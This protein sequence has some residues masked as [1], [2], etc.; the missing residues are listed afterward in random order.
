MRNRTVRVSATGRWTF[1]IGPEFEVLDNGDSVQAVHDARMAYVSS[2]R[3]GGPEVLIPSAQLR[4]TAARSLGSGERFSH[5][6]DS[7]EGDAEL[8]LDSKIWRLRGTMCASGTVATCMIDLPSLDA[9]DW[10]ISV[11]RSLRCE[12]DAA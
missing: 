10:A 3:V 4:A 11:W 12:G 2:L 6:G 5:V 1:I 7:V 9:R 8:F